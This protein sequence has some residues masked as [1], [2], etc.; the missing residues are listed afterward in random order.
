MKTL[1]AIALLLPALSFADFTAL[2]VKPKVLELK[3][4][5]EI[6]DRLSIK[7]VKDNPR[8]VINLGTRSKEVNDFFN[9]VKESDLQ[10]LSC[11]GDFFLAF[12]N[13]GMQYIHINSIKAC[14]DE[15]GT[16][17]AHSIGMDRLKDDQVAASKKII[18]EA[19]KPVSANPPIIVNNS[20][21]PKEPDN[22]KAGFFS[23][24]LE[25]KNVSK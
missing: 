16:V 20:N 23:P 5:R 2:A 17:V 7:F 13:M 21:K 8:I 10:K 24:K 3:K 18:E 9:K 4:Y 25:S 6:S 22:S 1:L 12:D 11:D 15:E 19:L 14:L